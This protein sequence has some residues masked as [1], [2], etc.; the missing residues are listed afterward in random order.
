MGRPD[1]DAFE[2]VMEREGEG[3]RSSTERSPESSAASRRLRLLPDAEQECAAFRQRTG[4]RIK[5]LT[6]QRFSDYSGIV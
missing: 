5:L 3:G 4:R 6:V 1:I 2:A